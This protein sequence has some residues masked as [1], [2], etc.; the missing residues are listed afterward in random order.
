M[1]AL[2][3]LPLAACIDIV[4]IPEQGVY[5]LLGPDCVVPAP[6][7]NDMA[8]LPS[9]FPLGCPYQVRQPDGSLVTFVFNGTPR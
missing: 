2:L 9:T 5:R 3:L 1:R 7:V 8:Q 4:G 6:I